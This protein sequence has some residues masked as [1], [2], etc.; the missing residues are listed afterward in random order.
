MRLAVGADVL[1]LP[2]VG[3]LHG[4]FAKG[5]RHRHPRARHRGG[6]C[7]LVRRALLRVAAALLFWRGRIGFQKVK[8]EGRDE[9]DPIL[10]KSD[11]YTQKEGMKVT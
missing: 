7:G 2:P 5:H 6:H 8:R 3:V 9:E 10:P 1:P 11:K 4:A